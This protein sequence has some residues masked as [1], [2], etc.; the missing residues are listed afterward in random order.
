MVIPTYNAERT[1]AKVIR[2]I[3]YPVTAIYVV[4]D[5]SQD[6]SV[7]VVRSLNDPRVVLLRNE[8]NQGVGGATLAGYRQAWEDGAEIVLKMDADDQMDPQ[9]IPELIAPIIAGE[10]SY[11][12]G[13]RFLH[14]TQLKQMPGLRLFGNF[15]LSLLTKA[16]SGYWTIFDPTNGFTAIHR[17]L[18]PYLLE[19]RIDKRFFFE[20]SV[21][22]ELGLHRAVVKDVYIPARYPNASRSHLSEVKALFTF[23][24]KLFR[25][26]FRRLWVQ[27]VV[28]DFGLVSV[29]SLAGSMLVAA[30]GSYGVY[31]WAHSSVLNQ[32]TPPGTVMLSALP[33]LMG[34][35]LLLQALVF[36]VLNEPRLP[37]QRNLR[38]KH[39]AG[40]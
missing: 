1:I 40:L 28:R 17:S 6:S 30:G 8:S 5:A 13:N 24:L 38:G 2:A 36:D 35:L 12:K 20:I 39:E 21:L 15:G 22:T 33:V 25:R 32:P 3:D 29:F 11:T 31:H 27:Y 14:L 16:A 26:F 10:A 19:G 7:E 23:P 18:I 9:R 34:F 4:D 37:I